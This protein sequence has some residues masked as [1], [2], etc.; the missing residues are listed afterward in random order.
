M[1]GDVEQTL[2]TK[3]L[4]VAAS[5]KLSLESSL[6]FFGLEAYKFRVSQLWP[7]YLDSRWQE[8]Q[9]TAPGNKRIRKDTYDEIPKIWEKY[10]RKEFET[11]RLIEAAREVRWNK[12]V[13]RAKVN[14]LANH[15]KVWLG[16][17][18]FCKQKGHLNIV[19]D[20]KIPKVERR[21]RKTLTEDEIRLLLTNSS[22][23]LLLYNSMYLFM[24]MRNSEIIAM[25]WDR[26]NFD[27]NYLFL[28]SKDVKT[29]KARAML[30][31]PVVKALLFETKLDQE[32]EGLKTPYVFP[33]RGEP[34]KHTV[35]TGLRKRW[36]HTIEKCGWEVG[37]VTPHDLRAT[38]EHY[39]N[40]RADFTD[41]QREKFAGA[42]ISVQK[43]IYVD[44]KP[45]DL[46]GLE[47]VV[48]VS[49]IEEII[50]SSWRRA[51]N[52]LEGKTK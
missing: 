19:P 49:G 37:F 22:K 5:K 13:A 38:Y 1:R 46:K 34:K 17:L 23:K 51:G 35:K 6:S 4:K 30:M 3:D 43:N 32:R 42:S 10:L 36:E 15:K 24:A 25:S 50:L 48:Q 8:Y 31:N 26:I 40:K 33:K 20:L 27:E 52:L 2:D 14:D 16:F 9:G 28:R 39:S 12:Y 44:F 11:L 45:D 41:A 18:N 29:N 7:S 21:P 47:S